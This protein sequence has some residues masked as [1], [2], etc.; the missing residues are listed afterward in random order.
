M[1]AYAFVS[2]LFELD[3]ESTEFQCIKL[4]LAALKEIQYPLNGFFPTYQFAY[5]II[6]R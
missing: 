3:F 2:G 1:N 6:R 4:Q 5:D